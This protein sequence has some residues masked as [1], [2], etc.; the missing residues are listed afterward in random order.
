MVLEARAE[1][2]PA[3]RPCPAP[4]ILLP[5]LFQASGP[6]HTL[7]SLKS[8]PFPLHWAKSFVA[9]FK[10]PLTCHFLRAALCGSSSA[11][12]ACCPE[13]VWDS[14]SDTVSSRALPGDQD[15]DQACLFACGT[16][17]PSTVP[18]TSWMLLQCSLGACL[19]SERSRGPITGHSGW[20]LGSW[21]DVVGFFDPV[22]R[23]PGFFPSHKPPSRPSFLGG[24]SGK[25]HCVTQCSSV[26]AGLAFGV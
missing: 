4:L 18:G 21:G 26:R 12:L 17:A 2:Y 13:L 10:S 16:P 15:T 1:S 25:E 22:P 5:L 8:L 23:A 24:S 20:A 7:S 11:S 6:S 14:D 19:H 3:P 9:S